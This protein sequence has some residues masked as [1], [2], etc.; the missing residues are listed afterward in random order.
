MGNGLEG[1]KAT[2]IFARNGMPY[3]LEVV[4]F[5]WFLNYDRAAQLFAFHGMIYLR[6]LAILFLMSACERHRPSTHPYIFYEEGEYIFN[7]NFSISIYKADNLVAATLKHNGKDLVT[8]RPRAST[9][10]TWFY[11]WD[12]GASKLW[13]YSGDVGVD[14]WQMEGDAFLPLKVERSEAELM[15]KRAEHLLSHP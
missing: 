11:Y 8:H 12:A 6:I 7:G 5:I 14:L 15:R 1:G 4:T 13:F 2:Q 10:H 3:V 9:Y